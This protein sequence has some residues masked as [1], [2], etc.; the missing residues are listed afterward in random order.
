MYHKEIGCQSSEN[1]NPTVPNPRNIGTRRRRSQTSVSNIDK[2]ILEQMP[3]S[4]QI[5]SSLLERAREMD[6]E[7]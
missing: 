6:G 7:E 3:K 5:F 1:R 4:F 2:D